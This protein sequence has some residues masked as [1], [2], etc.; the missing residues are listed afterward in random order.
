VLVVAAAE[1]LTIMVM[2]TQVVV[3]QAELQQA[4][5]VSSS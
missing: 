4:A 3:E 1:L 2:Q 5:P